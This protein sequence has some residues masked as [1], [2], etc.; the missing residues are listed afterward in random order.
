MAYGFHNRG[1]D[2]ETGCWKRSFAVSY[3]YVGKRGKAA[4]ISNGVDMGN[5]EEWI[6]E[7]CR[8]FRHIAWLAEHINLYDSKDEGTVILEQVRH[9]GGNIYTFPLEAKEAY[10]ELAGHLA[11]NPYEQMAA[12]SMPAEK[13]IFPNSVEGYLVKVFDILV[14]VG[15]LRTCEE[16]PQQEIESIIKNMLESC[17]QKFQLTEKTYIQNLENGKKQC[18]AI[19]KNDG[20]RIETLNKMIRCGFVLEA[21]FAIVAGMGAGIC[22]EVLNINGWAAF[23]WGAAVMIAI[24]ADSYYIWKTLKAHS[25]FKILKKV[26]GQKEILVK[27]YDEYMRI[28]EQYF[29]VENVC[30]YKAEGSLAP[31]RCQGEYQEIMQLLQDIPTSG[32][33]NRWILNKMM[34]RQGIIMPL[35]KFCLVYA[36]VALVVCVGPNYVNYWQEKKAARAEEERKQQ[37]A[38]LAEMAAEDEAAQI[39]QDVQKPV[40]DENGFLFADSNE[41]LL[42]E[43]E[44]YALKDVEGMEFKELLG[45]ARNEIYARYGYPFNQDG[46]YYSHYMQ[47]EWYSSMSS[48]KVGDTDFNEYEIANRDLIVSIEKREGYR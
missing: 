35:G 15:F 41:R 19:F 46:P 30:H 27:Y 9:Y 1:M 24:I 11:D 40:F 25:I 7:Q 45:F 33:K 34:L 14:P 3:L 16:V 28:R 8:E 48:M 32:K 37:E 4:R 38:E 42:S 21:I 39:P 10:E 18:D 23:V 17:L 5:L 12:W 13:N 44:V 47:Y 36:A 26:A 20:N 43:E 31:C 22:L 6:R 29:T 2:W